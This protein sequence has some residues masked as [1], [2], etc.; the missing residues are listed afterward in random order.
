MTV[1]G[2]VWF[3]NL[4][5]IADEYSTT[6][7]NAINNKSS[8]RAPQATPPPRTLTT[9][10]RPST[11]GRSATPSSLATT[12]TT[13]TPGTDRVPGRATSGV[14]VP[15]PPWGALVLTGLFW[16]LNDD[17]ATL[18]PREYRDITDEFNATLNDTATLPPRQYRDI[19]DEFNATSNDTA[20]VGQRRGRRLESES[21]M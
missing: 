5:T 9:R 1:K 2:S 15:W 6:I 12:G 3:R 19:T 13:C 21:W 14:S 20:N 18:P 8:R 11:S 7:S 10:S 4:Y 17:N 16:M